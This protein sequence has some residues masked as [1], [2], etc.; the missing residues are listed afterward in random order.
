[1]SCRTTVGEGNGYG[2]GS[3][4]SLSFFL[5]DLLLG[6]LADDDDD[7]GAR[8]CRLRLFVP[9]AGRTGDSSICASPTGVSGGV[10]E[11][12]CF[13]GIPCLAGKLSTKEGA[14]IPAW[15]VSPSSSFVEWKRLWW[16]GADSSDGVSRYGV[17]V[18]A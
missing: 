12:V 4:F 16:N 2:T 9:G 15:A 14:A 11:M 7:A 13:V 8:V 1:M 3:F 5:D 18:L 6:L 10:A 17:A